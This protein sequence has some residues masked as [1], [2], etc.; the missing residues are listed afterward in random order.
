MCISLSSGRGKKIRSAPTL[1]PLMVPV[2]S[3]VAVSDLQNMYLLLGGYYYYFQYVIRCKL[4]QLFSLSFP[5]CLLFPLMCLLY[6]FHKIITFSYEGIFTFH[7]LSI[8][9]KYNLPVCLLFPLV[10]LI[11]IYIYIYL[12]FLNFL[13]HLL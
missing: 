1:V 6:I 9:F 8:Q 3:M 5:Q 12:F 13:F 2:H 7:I 4:S 10:T 11:Y